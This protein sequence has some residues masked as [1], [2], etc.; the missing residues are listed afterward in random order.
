MLHKKKKQKYITN[1]IQSLKNFKSSS[2]TH[3]NSLLPYLHYQFHKNQS[4]ATAYHS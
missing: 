4:S 3:P 1:F 2:R